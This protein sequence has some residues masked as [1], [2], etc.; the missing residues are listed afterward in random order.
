LVITQF[1][2]KKHGPY[3]NKKCKN[4]RWGGG[5]SSVALAHPTPP[6][7]TTPHPTPPHPTQKLSIRHNF[8][9]AILT[10]DYNH[11]Y[12]HN[13]KVQVRPDKST[14][15]GKRVYY[16]TDSSASIIIIISSSSNNNSNRDAN[17][18]SLMQLS[19]L[20]QAMFVLQ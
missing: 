7:P 13:A 20:Q 6:H 17:L 8:I 10:Q 14:V 3:N 2:T 4:V 5:G 12:Q 9:T 18:C 19:P 11:K 16:L 15:Y 1:H